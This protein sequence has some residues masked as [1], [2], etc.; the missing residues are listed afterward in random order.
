M[1][2]PFKA[3]KEFFAR[4]NVRARKRRE[5]KELIHNLQSVALV[6]ETLNKFRNASMLY[7]DF[8]RNTVTIAQV[9]AEQFIYNDK[10]WQRFLGDVHLWAVYQFSVAEYTKKFNEAKANA[11]AKAYKDKPDLSEAD[12]ALAKMRAVAQLDAEYGGKQM[13]LPNIQFVVLG[14]ADGAPIVVAKLINGRYE[15]ASVPD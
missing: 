2:N 5:N 3:I 12:R 9:L 8:K 11:E 7:V 15:T 6:F 4:V 13:D 10:D 1:K 14:I